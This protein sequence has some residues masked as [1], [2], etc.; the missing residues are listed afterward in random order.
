MIGAGSSGSGDCNTDSETAVLSLEAIDGRL[1]T[2][3]E[4]VPTERTE[5]A[6]DLRGGMIGNAS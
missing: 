2:R 3:V 5:G 6:G 1:L 4:M